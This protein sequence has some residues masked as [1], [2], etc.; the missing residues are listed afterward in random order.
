MTAELETGAEAD[1]GRDRRATPPRAPDRAAGAS[2]DPASLGAEAWDTT[3]LDLELRFSRVHHPTVVDVLLER[4]AD[5]LDAA[6]P[7]DPFLDLLEHAGPRPARRVL[8][9]VRIEDLLCP[10]PGL[11]L[12]LHQPG[13][14]RVVGNDR[15]LGA[16]ALIAALT[17][18]L[19]PDA[20]SLVDA[21]A[22]AGWVEQGP[23]RRR[24]RRP[25]TRAGA[26]WPRGQGSPL[27][28]LATVL[29]RARAASRRT[30]LRVEHHAGPEAAETDVA[31]LRCFALSGGPALLGE[32][33]GAL[34]RPPVRRSVLE[35]RSFED[36]PDVRL[37]WATLPGRARIG[38]VDLQLSLHPWSP[39]AEHDVRVVE[40]G[41]DLFLSAT[42]WGAL[43]PELLQPPSGGSASARSTMA[44]A[45][46]R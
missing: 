2:L 44:S 23:P 21:F 19:D 4:L 10:R 9:E 13:R 12:E 38:G 42:S 7:G 15:G 30:A 5:H 41:P 6:E 24:P 43:P 40:A 34:D 16:P 17:P 37:E 32:L 3:R 18:L 1:G 35:P 25:Q 46:A 31:L 36:V 26:R 20:P 8:A 45:L 28:V 33:A 29:E 11:Y 14:V 39:R 22:D 27:E